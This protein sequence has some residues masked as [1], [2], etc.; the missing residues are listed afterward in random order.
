M[1]GAVFESA[2]RP[3]VI[4]RAVYGTIVVTSVLVIYDGWANLRVLGAAA[5]ILG[6][7]SRWSSRTYSP[8]ASPVTPCH[9]RLRNR[10]L[11]VS[12]AAD[13]LQRRREA[14]EAEK[15]HRRVCLTEDIDAVKDARPNHVFM[16]P[17]GFPSV[18]VQSPQA[19]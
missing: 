12:R 6:P 7:W 16:S 8:R 1:S 15:C 10:H 13:Q 5:I 14:A 9:A 4:D 18:D 19:A 2:G 17:L 3:G 11:Q